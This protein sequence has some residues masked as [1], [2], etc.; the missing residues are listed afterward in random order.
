MI[1]KVYFSTLHFCL[2][3]PTIF[4]IVYLTCWHFKMCILIRHTICKSLLMIQNFRHANVGQLLCMQ[5]VK[6]KGF[7]FIFKTIF[8]QV[9]QCCRCLK[10]YQKKNI[11]SK[12]PQNVCLINTLI[13]IYRYARLNF[14]LWKVLWNIAFFCVFSYIIDEHL[15]LNFQRLCI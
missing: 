2:N 10:K 12:L 4:V 9:G 6:R 14:R 8:E 7:F 1:T 3:I 15:W 13:L 11:F 5:I